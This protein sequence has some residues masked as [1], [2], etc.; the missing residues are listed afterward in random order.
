MPRT[1]CAGEGGGKARGIRREPI[2]WGQSFWF[3]ARTKVSGTAGSRPPPAVCPQLSASAMPSGPFSQSPFF[4]DICRTQKRTSIRGMWALEL[5]HDAGLGKLFDRC[6]M[7]ACLAFCP[8]G[9]GGN[10]LVMLT[11]NSRYTPPRLAPRTAI[12]GLV[13]SYIPIERF[14]HDQITGVAAPRTQLCT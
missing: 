14:C 12:S 2:Q 7:C 8:P 5:S 13:H 3:S 10:V 1:D 4:F 11:K 9:Q 6:P